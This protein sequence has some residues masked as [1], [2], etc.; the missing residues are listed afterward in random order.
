MA[1]R[2]GGL[3]AGR[4]RGISKV[5]MDEPG[6]DQNGVR[7]RRT[8]NIVRL[9]NLYEDRRGVAKFDLENR[10]GDFTGPGYR[11]AVRTVFCGALEDVIG[12]RDG[13]FVEEAVAGDFDLHECDL[14]QVGNVRNIQGL[15]PVGPQ[16]DKC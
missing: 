5:R 6:F 4:V 3:R 7:P 9:G 15:R 14:S 13:Y 8:G 16:W 10:A 1:I 12:A 2:S 11:L